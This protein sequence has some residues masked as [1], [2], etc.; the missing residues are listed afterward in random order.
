MS[1]GNP[2]DPAIYG[3]VNGVFVTLSEFQEW[4]QQ[5]Y[6]AQQ[7]AASAAFNQA[8]QDTGITASNPYVTVV[9]STP[10]VLPG[11]N[12]STSTVTAKEL[13]FGGDIGSY[14]TLFP[15]DPLC[16]LWGGGGIGVDGGSGGTVIEE[17]VIIEQ[18]IGAAD[19]N[20]AIDAGLSSVWAAVVG[21]LDGVLGLLVAGLQSALTAIGNALKAAYAVLARLAG[22]VLQALQSAVEGVLAGI[23]GVLND[24]RDLL[25]GLYNDVIAPMVNALSG[26]RGR[27]LSWYTQFIRPMLIWIQ[28][29]RQLLAILSIFHVKF[30]Q[31]LDA[32]LADLESRITQPLFYLL[33][34][35]N[36]IANFMNLIVT[37]TYLLQQPLWLFSLQ[38]YM[39]QSL[40][41]MFNAMTVPVDIEALAAQNAA[42][43]PPSIQQSQAAGLMYLQIG[44]GP[45]AA[46]AAQ[47]TAD[48]TS[49]LAQGP[50]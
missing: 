37:G 7:A 26:L 24:V 17:P 38:A 20:A 27:L 30:A 10:P 28:S 8:E 11:A 32:K 14:C 49:D 18:G 43:G 12:S 50:F 19:V 23:V 6:A 34:F 3:P 16:D 46:S 13:G 5:T 39:G 45:N 44:A 31:K 42:N 33:A 35:T 40:N 41:M 36:G 21:S 29:L 4:Q 15:D 9:T 47:S 48:L 1:P 22:F 25:K 2:N